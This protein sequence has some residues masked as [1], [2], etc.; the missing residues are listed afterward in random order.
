M[1][2]TKTVKECILLIVKCWLTLEQY[3]SPTNYT[4]N[5]H[6]SSQT[7]TLLSG[8]SGVGKSTIMIGLYGIM[9]HYGRHVKSL[10]IDYSIYK[11]K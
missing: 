10:Y 7:N 6:W 5:N 2:P 1:Y 4:D 8:A 9:N 3:L 11:S